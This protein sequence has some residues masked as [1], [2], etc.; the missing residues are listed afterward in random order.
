MSG[1]HMAAIRGV[2]C[3]M[4]S[5]L[6]SDCQVPLPPTRRAPARTRVLKSVIHATVTGGWNRD[7]HSTA[8]EE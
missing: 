1:S 5:A 3:P 8:R 7:S 4:A 2:V 6:K